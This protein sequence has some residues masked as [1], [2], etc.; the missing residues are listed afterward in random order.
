M[1]CRVEGL[2]LEREAFRGKRFRGLKGFI[3]TDGSTLKLKLSQ[4]Q[5]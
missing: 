5:P 2:G 4:Y 3:A 1:G